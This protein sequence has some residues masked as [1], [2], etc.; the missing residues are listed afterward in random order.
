MR[1]DLSDIIPGMDRT[2][3]IGRRLLYVASM[4][5]AGMASAVR[6]EDS[7]MTRAD[8]AFVQAVA[9]ADVSAAK[10]LIDADV[11]WITAQGKV[12]H[13]AQVLADVPKPAIA[14]VKDAESKSYTYGGLGNVQTN[15]GRAHVLRVWVKRPAGWRI[16]VYQELLS[17]ETPPSFTPGAGKDCENPCKTIAF[18]PKNDT[19]RQVAMAYSKLETA[20]HA[21]NSSAFGPMVGDEFVAASS[22]SDKL[23]SKRSR[24][25][26][27]DRSKDGGVAPTPLLSARMF[28]FGDAV[29]MLSEHKPDR[30]NPL[31][32]TRIWVKRGGSWVETLSYQTAVASAETAIDDVLRNA[33]DQGK[34]PGVVAMA[35]RGDAILFQGAFGSRVE[36]P[37]SPMTSDTI[38]R[39]A[40]MTKPVTSVAVMQLVEAGKVKLD[41]PAGEY[42]PDIAKAQVI[43]HIDTKTGEPVMRAPKTPVTVRELLSHTSGYV[44]DRW[45]PVLHEYRTKVLASGVDAAAFKEPLMFD[46]GTKWQYG[47]S[48]AWLGRLVEAVSGQ[49]LEQYCQQKIF[50][51]LGMVD[52]SYDVTPEKQSRLVTLHQRSADGTLSEAPPRPLQP[53]TAYRGDNGLY[54]TAA[55][56]VKFMR[57]ILDGGQSGNARILRPETV[58]M[59]GMNQIGGLSLYEFKSV[60]PQQSLD[61]RIP[62]GLDKFG[63]GFA[64]NTKAVDGGRSAASLAWAGL[65][66]TYFWIDPASKTTAVIMMQLLPFLDH[67]ALETLTNFERAVYAGKR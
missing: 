31:H 25:E 1:R 54:S 21:R 34:V 16:L 19:E 46:P 55:D 20:A 4:L 8:A 38:F 65:D 66:N 30:G 42:L 47:T 23:Q 51:P 52:T 43:D 11:S 32:V 48:T 7:A 22:Y 9:K 61:G 6:G 26:D 15:M 24:M 41:A 67:G 28:A 45:D 60:V 5:L 56:Y 10:K 39:I 27:F 14:N 53:V 63:L 17:L 44:Y 18:S 62:G 29:L 36:H 37:A 64:I 33:V 35:T 40:S 12:L 49:T 57:M 2:R 50:I 59:M 58:A 13:Q 3:P